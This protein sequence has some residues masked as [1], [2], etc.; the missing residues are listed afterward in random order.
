MPPTFRPRT[1]A[2]SRYL[3][4][5]CVAASALI[6]AE[7]MAQV[8]TGFPSAYGIVGTT[9]GGVT[10]FGQ[11]AQYAAGTDSY[12]V[13][14]QG[15]NR[16][17]D[18]SATTVDPSNPS[19]FWTIQEVAQSA[20]SWQ[21]QI[22]QF[23]VG[24]NNSF[25]LVNSFGGTTLANSGGWVPPDSTLA[26]GPSSVVEMVNNRYA[27][28]N[29][30]GGLLSQSSLDNF[31]KTAG[32]TPVNF[33]Y[34]PRLL[35]DSADGRWIAAAADNAGKPDNFLLAVSNTSDPTAGWKAYAI[36]VNPTAQIWGDFPTLG[37]NGAGIFLASNN[38]P[39][40]GGSTVVTVDKASLL[41]GTLKFSRVENQ[42]NTV[43]G[44]VP[45]PT[46]DLGNGALPEAVLGEFNTP[47]GT[48]RRSDIV[49]PLNAATVTSGPLITVDAH[50]APVAATQPNGVTPLEVGDT[51]FGSSV[52]RTASNDIWAV[53]T[54]LDPSFNHDSI[55]WLDINAATNTVKQQGLI[56][57][58]GFS[59]FYPSVAVNPSGQVAIG[60][61]GTASVTSD[62]LNSFVSAPAAPSASFNMVLAG[63]QRSNISLLATANDPVVN[64][65][66]YV[67]K[68][69][70]GKGN[71]NISVSLNADGNTVLTFTGDNPILPSYLF[72]YG[73][74]PGSP[75]FGFDGAQGASVISQYWSFSEEGRQALPTL[76]VL[77]PSLNPDNGGTDTGSGDDEGPGG[78]VF[79]LEGPT[80]FGLVSF[81]TLFADIASNGDTTGTWDEVAFETRTRPTLILTNPT[82]FTET[83]SDVGFLLSDTHI[84][85]DSL[86]FGGEPPPGVPGSMFDLLAQ[87]D[88]T[89]LCPNCSVDITLPA[90]IPEL[91]VWFML[92]GG[93]AGLIG[94]R[95]FRRMANP[96][97]DA[98][99]RRK[100]RFA[101]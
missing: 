82:D 87:L 3:L 38:N 78:D 70:V 49:G 2:S 54:V 9:S 26:A 44:V 91:P 57:D 40:G 96:R 36:P 25:N 77:G 59:F 16:F 55:R 5:S 22:A 52:V 88:G 37:M 51:R 60:F 66:A 20:S 13:I 29:K 94:L 23:S 80:P 43:S 6:P 18:Y 41:T 93:L 12:S 89:T 65:F 64:A 50:S 73:G 79:K 46:V 14:S 81:A 67:N 90:P 83:L 84:P 45:Q 11:A 34:D 30:S 68:N 19:R 17:G 56:R 86:N 47:A 61:S 48:V 69:I 71:A 1:A 101:G 100:A 7:A 53:Q 42:S 4:M 35:Y 99:I 75:H 24:A 28:Y 72:N 85:L 97:S 39:S 92:C 95:E 15:R 31:W 8:V 98:A 58:A 21:T 27:V 63:D 32:V 76:T 62:T 10:T 74:G 33:S